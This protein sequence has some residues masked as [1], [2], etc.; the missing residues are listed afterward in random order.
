MHQAREA[1]ERMARES[2]VSSS[3][4]A[5]VIGITG[6]VGAG[7]STLARSLS[8]CIL[9]TDDY[10]PD[11]ELIPEAERDD[12]RHADFA[13]LGDNLSV[14]RKGGVARVPTWSFQSHSRVGHREIRS[15]ELIVVEGIHAFHEHPRVSLDLAVFVEAPPAIRWDR[16]EY[17]EATGQRGWGV[18]KARAFFH[19]VAEPTFA[20]YEPIYRARAHLIVVNDTGVPS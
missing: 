7:K 17:L 11:Y 10:L 5:F 3:P 18:E 8:P 15:H 4:G 2:R 20:R 13:L 12:P 6:R 1:I 16:W 14:L 19:A 9:A